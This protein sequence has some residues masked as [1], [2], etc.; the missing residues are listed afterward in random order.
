MFDVLDNISLLIFCNLAALAFSLLREPN[1]EMNLF[2]SFESCNLIT[3]YKAV[4]LINVNEKA[5]HT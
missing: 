1:L 3:K 5:D 2:C 4:K